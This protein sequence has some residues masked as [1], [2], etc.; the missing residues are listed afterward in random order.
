VPGV[1]VGDEL[2]T[3]EGGDAESYLAY[4]CGEDLASTDSAEAGCGGGEGCSACDF[5]Q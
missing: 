5:V 1:A 2:A 3:F 4:Q